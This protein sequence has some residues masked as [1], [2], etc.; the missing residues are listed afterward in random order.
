[1]YQYTH[2]IIQFHITSL[3]N[4]KDEELILGLYEVKTLSQP[5]HFGPIYHFTYYHPVLAIR[6]FLPHF[7]T[8]QCTLDMLKQF[9][10]IVTPKAEIPILPS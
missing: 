1:M 9:S 10:M 4:L 8:S 3:V 5:V 7:D 2:T 6:T